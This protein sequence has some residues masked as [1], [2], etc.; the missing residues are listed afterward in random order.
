[1]KKSPKL[2]V[3]FINLFVS[4]Y[5]L[6][7]VKLYN[8]H[9]L[10]ISICP[11]VLLWTLIVGGQ[12]YV[13][14]D[15]GAYLNYFT[16]P[17][18]ENRFEP[19]FSLCSNILVNN[20]FGGQF[21]FFVFGFIN[22]VLIFSSA[23]KL[24]I[25]YLGIFYFLLITVST[26]FNNQMNG[27][28]QCIATAFCFFAFSELNGSKIKG[29][30]FIIIAM[31]FHYSAL[32]FVP[33]FLYP[34]LIVRLTSFPKLL[35]ICCCACSLIQFDNGLI[36]SFFLHLVPENWLLETNY[37]SYES[38]D[39][40]S[41]SSILI[42]LSKIFLLPVYW[43]SLK[44]LSENVLSEKEKMLY[45]FGFFAYNLRMLLMINQ[46]IGRFSYYFWI[47][48]IIPIYFLARYFIIRN[49]TQKLIFLLLYVSISYFTKVFMG[50]AEY[51]YSFYLF[52]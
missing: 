28:R 9:E 26:F 44:L 1:M 47:P 41:S 21:P 52:N 4:C 33:F 24:K 5:L 18:F 17:F 48:S 25:Q 31:G 39:Y 16:P 15:Y 22:C 40:D 27:I 10:I 49:E 19:L 6:S 37:L 23:Y 32:V 43:F 20:G 51:S 11:V 35:L 13:G 7:K 14:T 12:Y 2:M 3:Y 36:N 8:R 30:L 45:F 50:F 46:L 38:I 34:K 29:V 42:K